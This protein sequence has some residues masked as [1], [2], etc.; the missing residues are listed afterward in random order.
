MGS[1]PF[2]KSVTLFGALL[3]FVAA[4][5][6][7]VGQE[8]WATS[9]GLVASAV[10]GVGRTTANKSLTSGKKPGPPKPRKG[11]RVAAALFLGVLLVGCASSPER[12]EGARD[13]GLRLAA[14]TV[15]RMGDCTAEAVV[16]TGCVLEHGAR[17]AE[18]RK[19][20]AECLGRTAVT[21]GVPAV[22]EL[23]SAVIFGV[24]SAPEPPPPDNNPCAVEAA[25]ACGDNLADAAAFEACLA[26]RLGVCL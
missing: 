2:Y 24:T 1:K 4:I 8:A 20:W 7:A 15:S 16:F 17:C 5:L 6:A 9:V 18:V 22:A 14:C 13:A 19:P 26:D 12:R 25:D 21:C 11:H 10:V 23:T 3:T